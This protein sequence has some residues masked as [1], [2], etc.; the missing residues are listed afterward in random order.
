MIK[1]VDEKELFRDDP[2]VRDAVLRLLDDPEVRDGVL[3]FLNHSRNNNVSKNI[4]Q[5]IIDLT[6]K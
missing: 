6:E 1:R 5:I 4:R 3:S 2:E